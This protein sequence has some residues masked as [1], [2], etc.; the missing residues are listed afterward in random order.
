MAPIQGLGSLQDDNSR[1][2]QPARN[3]GGGGQGLGGSVRK[4]RKAGGLFHDM[5]DGVDKQPREESYWD[6]WKTTF[7]PGFTMCSATFLIIFL[8][9]SFFIITLVHTCFLENGMNDK[10]FLGI[11]PYTLQAFGMRMPYYMKQG[12]I[13]RFFMPLVLNYGMSTM[14]INVIVQL[15]VGFILEEK[16]GSLRMMIYYLIAGIGGTLVGAIASDDYAA[17]AEPAMFGM[18]AGLLGWYMFSWN[19]FDETQC[20][21]GQRLCYFLLLILI[22]GFLTYFLLASAKPYEAYARRLDFAIPDGGA[23]LGGFIYGLSAILWLL[24]A[25][26]DDGKRNQC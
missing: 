26:S 18:V 6:M 11:Q 5:G 2:R 20:S 9:L 16:L 12:Q 23:A 10:F 22:V 21:F 15:I 7:C 19:S 13:W 8:Q 24:P 17:G 4:Q 14:M 25:D 3:Q 1:G